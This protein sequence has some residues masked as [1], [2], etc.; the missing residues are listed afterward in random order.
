MCRTVY[1]D[2]LFSKS[3]HRKWN[4][5]SEVNPMKGTPNILPV[6]RWSPVDAGELL[7]FQF[8]SLYFLLVW[9]VHTR[10]KCAWKMYICCCLSSL[11]QLLLLFSDEGDKHRVSVRICICKFCF[12]FEV[13]L[14]LGR[15]VLFPVFSYSCDYLICPT[16]L[17]VFLNAAP[18]ARLCQLVTLVCILSWV[19]CLTASCV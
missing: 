9:W 3:V 13:W 19:P 5:S 4:G 10:V 7:C 18:A 16:C 15:P 6:M 11:F 12:I 2:W 1:F 14:L 8:I 17:P